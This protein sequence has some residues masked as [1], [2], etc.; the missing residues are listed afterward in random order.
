MLSTNCLNPLNLLIWYQHVM[1]SSWIGLLILVV[2][3][4]TRS[5]LTTTS[6]YHSFIIRNSGRFKTVRSVQSCM[7]SKRTW[8]GM[9]RSATCEQVVSNPGEA[10]RLS[11]SMSL[12]CLVGSCSSR[13]PFKWAKIT[14]FT[15]RCSSLWS[16]SLL[17]KLRQFALL[18]LVDKW[19]IHRNLF[20]VPN[21]VL[22][23][24]KF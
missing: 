17:L 13:P 12:Q 4:Q 9:L 16:L 22:E 21:G 23:D 19:W 8:L 20:A 14:W 24:C 7:C 6:Q 15:K 5:P 1:L 3:I 11:V 2:P 10:L 18:S